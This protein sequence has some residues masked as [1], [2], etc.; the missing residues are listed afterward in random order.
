MSPRVRRYE[1]E[2]AVESEVA[3]STGRLLAY[4]KP[5]WRRMAIAFICLLVTTAVGLAFPYVIQNLLDV[6]TTQQDFTMLNRIAGGLLALFAFRFFF[7]YA[8]NYLISY[9]GE[10]VIVDVRNQVYAHLHQLSLRFFTERRVGELVSRL[11]SDVTLI[12]T[13]LTNNVTTVV[14]QVLTFTGALVIIFLLNWRLTFFVLILAPVVG[15]TGALFG[16]RL[17]AISTDVQDELADSTTIIEEA[18]QGIRI[19]K[20]FVREAYEVARYGK[21][22]DST[23]AAAMRL[24]RVRAAFGPLMYLLAFTA[25]TGVLWYGG[26]EV[27]AGRL[28]IGGL[29]GFLFYAM[30]IAGSIGAF[31]NLYT[32]LQEAIGATRR[33]FEILDTAPG[34]QDRPGATVIR[35]VEGRLGFEDVHFAYDERA[36]VLNGIGLIVELGEVLALVGPSGAGKS[37]VF[38]LIPRFY[39]PSQG[40][41]TLDGHD[42]R[43][44]TQE[45]LRQQIGIVPQETLL[46]GGTIRE[47]ILYGRLD[48]SQDELV[49]AARTANAHEFIMALPDGY[50]TVVGE[51]GARLSGGQRQRV[52]IARAVLKDPRILLLDEATSSLDSES[53]SLVQEALERLMQGRTTVIIA[54]RLST[55]QIADR[56]AV[57]DEGRLVEVGPHEALIA[58]GGL[59]ARLHA[60]QF[61]TEVP[62]PAGDAVAYDGEPSRKQRGTGR[63]F[64]LPNLGDN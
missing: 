50:E 22:L 43:D 3:V 14:S 12:R 31:T 17:R 19:V 27:V 52:A 60:M 1:D 13:V 36:P 57:L 63:F 39:D 54:H 46:F 28:T 16:R 44:L 20:S 26:R 34:V 40:R 59:Y 33:V 37:T 62:S 6:I 47:N 25:I 61:Q 32:Q 8:Q 10:R 38:N 64:G 41:V 24:T 2:M 9:I 55:V 29:A 5:Y 30:T 35:E 53:E 21:A 15:L 23:F 11:S 56:I 18:L 51:R 7:G 58:N 4:L 48:A 42:L 49:A 45:S